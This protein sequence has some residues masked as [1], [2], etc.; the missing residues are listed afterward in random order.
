MPGRPEDLSDTPLLD[1]FALMH[2]TDA[3]GEFLHDPQ[4]VGDEQQTHAEA[5][6]QIGQKI[7]HLRLHGDIERGRGFVGDEQPRIVGDGDGDGDHHPLRLPARKLEG[8]G[9]KLPFGFGNA[10]KLEQ[11]QRPYGR[12]AALH[13]F[14]HDEDFD[15]L[16]FNRKDRIERAHRLLKDHADAAAAN[17]LELL[18]GRLEQIDPVQHDAA[19]GML[20]L[21]PRQQPRDGQ[22]GNRFARA[23]FSDDAQGFAGGEVEGYAAHDRETPPVLDEVGGKIADAEERRIFSHRRGPA[24]RGGK[25]AFRR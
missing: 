19:A 3:V 2:D 13:V 8:K 18:V 17:A 1:H 23:G 9:A 24:G 11:F 6:L 7:E 20:R 4:I 21:A 22:R 25:D 5:P 14:V 10:D 16:L 15:D 12:S